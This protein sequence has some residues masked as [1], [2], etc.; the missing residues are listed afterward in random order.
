MNI[1]YRALDWKE[2]NQISRC[3]I[4]KEIQGTFQAIY[5]RKRDEDIVKITRQYERVLQK[6]KNIKKSESRKKDKVSCYRCKEPKHVKPDCPV[7]KYK[8]KPNKE[9]MKSIWDDKFSCESDLSEQFNEDIATLYLMA[10][11][12]SKSK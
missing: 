5:D 6:S 3:K 12:D 9:A 2:F 4:A 1:F 11:E 10:M 7:W 8:R